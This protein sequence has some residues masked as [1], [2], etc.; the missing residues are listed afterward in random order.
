MRKKTYFVLGCMLYLTGCSNNPSLEEIIN[1]QTEFFP[2]QFS[3]Q[4][5]KEIMSFPSTRSMP[6]NA[7]PEPSVSKAGDYQ[8]QAVHLQSY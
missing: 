2:V 5:E 1:P 4:M 3:I 7:I 6:D 8:A